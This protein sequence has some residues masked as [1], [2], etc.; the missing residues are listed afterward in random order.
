M[1][2][3]ILM[4][5]LILGFFSRRSASRNCSVIGIRCM[6][7]SSLPKVSTACFASWASSSPFLRDLRMAQR[8]VSRS[9]PRGPL[10][11]LPFSG[12]FLSSSFLSLMNF[13]IWSE[14]AL[15]AAA[16]AKKSSLDTVCSSSYSLSPR[17]VSMISRFSS[18]SR[19]GFCLSLALF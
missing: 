10:F 2:P 6:P 7:P 4:I 11:T 18:V 16:E 13:M 1:R 17:A 5:S 19:G 14:N 9:M 12:S 8:R 3:S 15:V